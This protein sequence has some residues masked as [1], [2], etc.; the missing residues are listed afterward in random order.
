MTCFHTHT[1]I[2]G[3]TEEGK[4][5]KEIAAARELQHIR[6]MG[7][8]NFV[9]Q[10]KK[11]VVIMGCSTFHIFAKTISLHGCT[12][13][14]G[15]SLIIL[16]EL[17]RKYFITVIVIARIFY[18]VLCF[19]YK[20]VRIEHL[21]HRRIRYVGQYASHTSFMLAFN[22]LDNCRVDEVARGV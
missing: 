7:Y 22:A 1:G 8:S 15:Q 21:L 20:V 6:Y 13:N 9:S 14:C 18:E 17:L 12:N 16:I 5:K 11:G 2:R 4:P 10:C 19:R 3:V